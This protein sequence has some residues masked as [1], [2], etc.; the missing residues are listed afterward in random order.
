MSV[1][2]N[3]YKNYATQ[4]NSTNAAKNAGSAKDSNVTTST[5]I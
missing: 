2:I 5:A 1:E 3:A 4:T